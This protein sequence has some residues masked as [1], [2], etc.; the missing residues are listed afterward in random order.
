MIIAVHLRCVSGWWRS[1][2]VLILTYIDKYNATALLI[3]I[4][5][6]LFVPRKCFKDVEHMSSNAINA[7]VQRHG[8]YYSEQKLLA[9][10][11]SNPLRPRKE[12]ERERETILDEDDARKAY[13]IPTP[14]RFN[15]K[16]IS[17][18]FFT[19]P[20]TSIYF[21]FHLVAK[22]YGSQRERVWLL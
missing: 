19:W 11:S 9:S 21:V 10:S 13:Y 6:K 12:R 18:T 4:H 15:R 16:L 20:L 7:A 1:T 22:P 3:F 5:K 2:R 8:H 17:P 14:K